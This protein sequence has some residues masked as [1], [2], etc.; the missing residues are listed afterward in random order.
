VRI[1]A[2]RESR[3]RG[4]WTE[5]E[6]ILRECIAIREK[7]GPDD[8]ST[9]NTRSMLGSSLLGQQKFVDAEPLILAGYEGMKNRE[10]KMPASAKRR[11]GEAA[12]RALKLYEGWGKND[13]AAEWR[14]KLAIAPDGASPKR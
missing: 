13:K 5:A 7:S 9:F 4:T 14:A 11:L 2:R 3:R 8:W 6:T 10:A 1:E 12:E